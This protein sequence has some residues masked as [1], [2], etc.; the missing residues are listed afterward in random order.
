MTRTAHDLGEAIELARSGVDCM[1]RCPA[2]EDGSASLHVSPGSTHPVLM[3]C[4]AGCELEDILREGGI[5]PDMILAERANE[6]KTR[7]AVPA[8]QPIRTQRGNATHVYEYTDEDGA[9]LF[10]VLRIPMEGGR[11]SFSQRHL[12]DGQWVWNMQDVRRVLYRLPQVLEAKR[13]GARIWLVEGEK[14][15]ETLMAKF[16]QLEIDDVATTPPMG[17]NK[18]LDE[19]TETL[20]G[21]TVVIVSDADEPGRKHARAVRE[22]LAAAECNVQVVE[23]RQAG[24]KLVKDATDHFSMG[25]TIEN[26][27]VT[28]PS[29]QMIRESFGIDILTAITRKVEPSSF[30]IPNMLA[31]GDRM[32]ITGLEGHGKSTLLMQL[33]A[34]TAAGI[35]PWTGVEFDPQE[36]LFID[37]ENHPDQSLERWQNLVGLCAAHKHPIEKGML[38]LVEDWDSDV[39]LISPDGYNQ[40]MERIYAFKPKLCFVGPL[41]TMVGRDLKDDEVA[42]KLKR[43]I[44]NARAICGTAFIMEHHAPH[45]APGDRERSVRPY[46]SSIFLKWPDFGYGLKPT[47]TDHVYEWQRTR[48]PRV[49]SRFFPDF[50]RN[51]KPNTMEFPWMPA[52]K[53]GDDEYV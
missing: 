14:D 17:A 22:A 45:K 31:K 44:N 49:R 37:G 8:T 23:P 47:E 43:T 33:A 42:R 1:V 28:I 46:G 18:W 38:T 3:K 48:F 30:V 6:W 27:I 32:L 2:H 19:Y 34:M 11:K 25:G 20:A 9:M 36:V 35:H 41:Y 53:V 52:T 29:E 10:E 24:D 51:G 50:L 26:F 13:K 7:C 39:D 40:M 4:F 16:E 12:V 15:V 5:T 21:C